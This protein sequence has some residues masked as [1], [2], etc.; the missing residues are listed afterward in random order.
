MSVDEPNVASPILVTG[1]T[2]R[3]GGT[4]RAVASLISKGF[5]VRALVRQRDHRAEAVAAVR[6]GVEQH[7]HDV[8]ELLHTSN[9]G[10]NET[11]N[12]RGTV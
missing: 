3:H 2:G 9:G 8:A 12:G 1:T 11:E 6:R 5:R 10:R 7:A 4:G